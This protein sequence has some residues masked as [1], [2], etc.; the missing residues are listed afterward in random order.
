MKKLDDLDLHPEPKTVG[1]N[2]H[3]VPSISVRK[4]REGLLLPSRAKALL[5]ATTPNG[6][7][8]SARLYE[9]VSLLV[10]AGA[11]GE[12]A[13]VLAQSSAWNKFKDRDDESERI[14]EAVERSIADHERSE[15]EIRSVSRGSRNGSHVRAESLTQLIASEEPAAEWCVQGIWQHKGCGFLAGEPK[16]YKSTFALDL[17]VALASGVPFLGHFEV[18]KTGPVLIV[19][20]ENTKGIQR[21]R[22]LRILRER[23]LDGKV[24]EIVKGGVV[25][26]PPSGVPVYSM[27][28]KGFSFSSAQKRKNVE[29]EIR[30]LGPTLVI[31][32]PLQMMMGDLSV[33]K[34]GDVAKVLTWLNHLSES[35]G[36]G[37]LIVHHYHKRREEGPQLG[38][39]RMLG[40]QIL[41]AWLECGIYVQRVHGSRMRIDREYRAFMD[42]GPFELEFE[43]EDDEDFY[44]TVVHEQVREKSHPIVD[45]VNDRPGITLTEAA[46]KLGVEK[47]AA[48][49]AAKRSGLEVKKMRAKGET[50]R[51]QVRL[52]PSRNE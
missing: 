19:Q 13:Y 9:L 40:S 2:G 48:S 20:E 4:A 46:K 10:E 42:P 38:G 50:G 29:R 32:D 8:R 51:P 30:R 11:T 23:K 36:C 6:H 52:F 43:S 22:F 3:G 14:W 31:F 5:L 16:T 41:H 26:T 28:R 1:G 44:R 37:V 39:Q 21:S 7:D 34:E 49:K 17:A 45:L 18:P 15:A 25:I 35:Y 24:Q 47:P 33:R 12:A 27:N